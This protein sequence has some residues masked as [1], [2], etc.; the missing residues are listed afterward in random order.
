MGKPYG[1]GISQ[2][3]EMTE[4]TALV[5]GPDSRL[6]CIASGGEIPLNMMAMGA[7]DVVAVDDH[8]GQL[9][10]TA[11][12]IASVK[13]L[14]REDTLR[15]LGYLPAERSW[16]RRKWKEVECRIEDIYLP[17]WKD[18]MR[19]MARG[20]VHDAK[21]EWY[22][23][24]IVG[25]L[26]IIGGKKRFKDIFEYSSLE[27][28]SRHFNRYFDTRMIH[29]IFDL[30]LNERSFKKGGM[31]PKSLQYRDS[32]EPLSQYYFSRL[33][34]MCCDTPARENYFLQYHFLKR[35]IDSSKVPAFLK[36]ENYLILRERLSGLLL[37]RSDI[38]KYLRN[39]EVGRFNSFHISNLGDWFSQ[40]QFNSL[41][42]EVSRVSGGEGRVIWRFIHKDRIIP[43]DLKQKVVVDIELGRELQRRDRYPFYQIRPAVLH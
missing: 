24:K 8:P 6:V 16:R 3:D 14:D 40:E 43:D 26:K 28:Q 34:A 27:R 23:G 37:V 10:L 11:L 25:F 7:C 20:A 33:R 36:R 29:L 18:H 31:N 13:A 4:S 5:I 41:L 38:T 12:K 17:F 15:F 21:Y 42:R 30:A 2:E 32:S 22:V 39:T 19:T 9:A 35:V 1:F